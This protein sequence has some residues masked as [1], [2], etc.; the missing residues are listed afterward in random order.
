[1]PII[2]K[3][4]DILKAKIINS[5]ETQEVNKRVGVHTTIIFRPTE[6]KYNPKY[7][8]LTEKKLLQWKRD[9]YCFTKERQK[10]FAKVAKD[11][12]LDAR[13]DE[14]SNKDFAHQ[15]PK[16]TIQANGVPTQ[17]PD[18]ASNRAAPPVVELSADKV[19]EEEESHAESEESPNEVANSN[20]DA[21]II[22]EIDDEYR[23]LEDSSGEE[24][25]SELAKNLKKIRSDVP[26]N[27]KQATKPTRNSTT[28]ST[29]N[30]SRQQVD[31]GAT[32]NRT[33][34]TRQLAQQ[35]PKARES[36]P[37]PLSPQQ[38]QQ[39]PITEQPEP[40]WK[41]LQ[42]QVSENSFDQFRLIFQHLNHFKDKIKFSNM[43]ARELLRDITLKCFV[44]DE[45][46]Y[47][48][49]FLDLVCEFEFHSDPGFIAEMLQRL[50]R[51]INPH[52]TLHAFKSSAKT[53]IVLNNYK[54]AMRKLAQYIETKDMQLTLRLSEFKLLLDL[55]DLV[56][57]SILPVK[58][59]ESREILKSTDPNGSC[60]VQNGNAGLPN[61]SNNSSNS[62]G[63]QPDSHGT[64]SISTPVNLTA[65][66]STDNNDKNNNDR[67]SNTSGSVRPEKQIINGLPVRIVEDHTDPSDGHKCFKVTT[68]RKVVAGGQ[69]RRRL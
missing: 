20:L 35:P 55:G 43:D 13:Q 44:K 47:L 36:T 22:N 32:L 18:V 14:P 40:N 27:N 39:R 25:E 37:S 41:D 8:I 63:H 67:N 28:T 2:Y 31:A 61:V 58:K 49:D 56:N 38:E 16:E 24:E 65:T 54:L 59:E 57:K 66:P 62:N 11:I 23:Y 3:N 30:K 69:L 17:V 50:K 51:K 45:S 10:R 7:P 19:L 4:F 42:K 26:K 48:L 5:L 60:N 15:Q 29:D 1:M 21:L 34:S 6:L 53:E 9:P 12:Q 68:K 33:N 52:A 64:S 46:F